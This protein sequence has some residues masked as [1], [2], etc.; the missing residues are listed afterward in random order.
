ME[1][2]NMKY[3]APTVTTTSARWFEDTVCRSNHVCDAG[4]FSCSSFKCKKTFICKKTYK[5]S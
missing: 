5:Q 4:I 2:G 1:D 3:S